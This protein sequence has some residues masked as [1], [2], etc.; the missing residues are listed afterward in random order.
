VRRLAIIGCGALATE[1]VKSIVTGK[2]RNYKVVALL[3]KNKK[4]SRSLAEIL[5]NKELSVETIEE[6]LNRR[7]DIVVEVASPQAVREY[8]DRILE[9]GATLIVMSSGGLLDAQFLARLRE[10]AKKKR[11]K[12]I[13]PSGA[14]G[15]IDVAKALSNVGGE[16]R[17]KLITVKKASAFR[18]GDLEKLDLR[19]EDI[20]MKTLVFSGKASDAIK[21]FPTMINVAAT[22]SIALKHDIDVE[23]YADPTIEKTVHQI[24]IDS[25]ATR[26]SLKME[27][28]HHPE[29]P[30]TSY[31]AALSLIKTLQKLDEEL[32]VGT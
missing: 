32:E 9:A 16:V 31:I 5:G 24:I 1:I 10:I 7:P 18:D 28:M 4:R 15:C 23:I 27:N 17:V 14:I 8:A 21:F 19:R 3:D 6:L 20:K 13:V 11:T 2:L 30:R 26:I 25:P 29:N 22:L 12:I